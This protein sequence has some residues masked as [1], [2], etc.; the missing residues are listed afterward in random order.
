MKTPYGLLDNSEF[1]EKTLKSIAAVTGGEYYSSSTKD[2][3]VEIY[4]E[5]DKL[6]RTKLEVKHFGNEEERF[7]IFA[8]IAAVSL[9]AEILLRNTI[10]KKIP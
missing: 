4:K 1:D 3:L 9:M 5:I 6:E 7:M 8:L 2:G 10:L